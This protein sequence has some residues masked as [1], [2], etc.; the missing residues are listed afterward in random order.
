MSYGSLSL[1]APIP[2]G[3]SPTEEIF[4]RPR[5][6][7]AELERRRFRAVELLRRGESP[8]EVTRI[9]GVHPR[10]LSKWRTQEQEGTL[11]A[12]PHPGRT[13]LLSH[14]DCEKL[15]TLLLQ[16]S[17][18]H[19]WPND[20]WTGK[21]VQEVIQRHFAV[22]Y[23]VHYVCQFLKQFLNWTPQQPVHRS[24]GSGD[25][26]EIARWMGQE[27]PRILREA[28]ARKAWLLFVDETGFLLEPTARRTFAPR[29]QTPVHEIPNKHAKIST[30]GAIIVSPARD[31][32]HLAYQHLPDNENFQGPS[33]ASFVRAFHTVFDGPLT[34]IWDKTCIHFCRAVEEYLAEAGDVIL[35]A[36]P[37]YAPKLNPADGIWRYVKFQRLANYSPPD[38][39]TLREV[40]TLE[41]ESLK[42]R[43]GILKSFV[44]YTKLAISFGS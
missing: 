32:I 3:S 7:P 6:S 2:S 10:S 23:N 27:F 24:K 9:L 39:C 41:L 21:R 15:E 8:Q 17:T 31:R 30:I 20:L 43:P 37:P 5:G 33:V 25:E 40:V 44:R 12:K 35:E 42:G 13:R 29:G 1:S 19:G 11:K 26:A 18:G 14:Q 22:T 4:M 16:G 36:L 34:I 28:E 38:L